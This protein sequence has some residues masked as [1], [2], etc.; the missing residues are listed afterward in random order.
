MLKRI[1]D[2]ILDYREAHGMSRRELAA[3]S[4]YSEKSLQNYERAADV[5]IPLEKALYLGKKIMGLSDYTILLS[6]YVNTPIIGVDI[7][8]TV[9]PLEEVRN[10]LS[11]SY[12]ITALASLHH[13]FEDNELK[14]QVSIDTGINYQRLEDIR[15]TFYKDRPVE[16]EE[17]LRICKVL[18]KKFSELFGVVPEDYANDE[19]ALDIAT[20][21]QDY[22][23]KQDSNF[24]N[25]EKVDSNLSK[26]EVDYLRE[27]LAVFRKLNLK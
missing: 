13:A 18:G 8:G 16:I 21:L 3:K 2:I 5:W 1:H 23:E 15:Q 11:S 27:M 26:R 20:T 14:I 7:T 24:V 25:W 19:K 17:A 6:Y 9:I 22:I 12:S 4:K 10:L